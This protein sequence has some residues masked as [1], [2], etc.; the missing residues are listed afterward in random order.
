ML[1]IDPP[2]LASASKAARQVLKVP[3]RSM[4]TTA[5]KPLALRLAAGARK[6]PAAEL[7]TT[8]SRPNVSS[9]AATAVATAS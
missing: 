8:S 3:I 1:T 4:S 7:T 2:C 6:F 9:V 5:R